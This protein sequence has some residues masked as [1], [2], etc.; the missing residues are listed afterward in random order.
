MSDKGKEY[1]RGWSSAERC[2]AKGQDPLTLLNQARSSLTRDAFDRGWTDY[3]EYYIKEG[4]KWNAQYV[5]ST[6][7]GIM[8]SLKK[9]SMTVKQSILRCARNLWTRKLTR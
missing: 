1:D 2:I 4:F 3:C 7:D 9:A 8:S 6:Q 5:P